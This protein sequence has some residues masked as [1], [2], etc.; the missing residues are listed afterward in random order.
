MRIIGGKFSSRRVHSNKEPHNCVQGNISGYR[1]TT[2]RARETLFNVLNNIIDFDMARSL[3]LFAGSGAIGFE[4]LS[5][6]AASCDFVENAA[7]QINN[8]QKTACELGCGEQ[9][10][11]ISENVLGFLKRSGDGLGYYDIIFADPPYGYEFY[12]E[13]MQGVLNMKF[14]IFV[15][16]HSGDRAGM[17]N[18]NDFEI[19]EKKIGMTNF[20]ILNRKD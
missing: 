3:D 2:D 8:I 9:V 16:E 13:L 10:N 14:G 4:F 1:P 12:N 11:I 6:G 18:V 20:T 17:F 19:I 15:L 7:K 5:R